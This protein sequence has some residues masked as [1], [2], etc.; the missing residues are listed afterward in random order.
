MS[1]HE[2]QANVTWEIKCAD[3]LLQSLQGIYELPEMCLAE[4]LQIIESYKDKNQKL[5][6][7]NQKLREALDR[8]DK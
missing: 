3:K 5:A 4:Q 1:V 7:E 6:R 2:M 8:Q